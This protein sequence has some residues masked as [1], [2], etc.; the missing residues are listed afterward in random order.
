MILLMVLFLLV[1]W[2]SV[3]MHELGHWIVLKKY[4]PE[5]TINYEKGYFYVGKE[6]MYKG[7][8]DQT[9]KKV[10]WSGILLGFLPILLI[11]ETNGYVYL[12]LCLVYVVGIKHDLKQLKLIE[13][14]K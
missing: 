14:Q 8:D 6:Y 9:K 10:Y 13:A 5:A 1:L 3:L 12:F 2:L 7:L 4:Y 11:L